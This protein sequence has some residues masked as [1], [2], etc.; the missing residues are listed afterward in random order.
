MSVSVVLAHVGPFVWSLALA[1]PAFG[2]ALGVHRR[3]K[4]REARS[5]RA[6]EEA[7]LAIAAARVDVAWLELER[8]FSPEAAPTREAA[9]INRDVL[10][11]VQRLL[12]PEIAEIAR[13]CLQPLEHAYQLVEDG[14]RGTGALARASIVALLIDSRGEARPDVLTALQAPADDSRPT[15][16]VTPPAASAAS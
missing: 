8:A 3:V 16:E 9:A 7:R 11:Q 6:L 14:G 13:E 15:I 10:L 4:T 1:L 5:R 2:L 12:A